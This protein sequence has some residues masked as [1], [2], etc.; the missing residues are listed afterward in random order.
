VIIR[1]VSERKRA[2]EALRAI[3]AGTAASKGGKL[4]RTL[5][6]HL[7][8]ALCVRYAFIAQC[9][10]DSREYVCTLAFWK[11]D[12]F[13]ENFSYQLTGTPCENVVAGEI[14]HYPDGVQALFPTDKVL[15]SLKAR[16][17]LGIPLC[18]GDGREIGYLAV[19]DDKRIDVTPGDM[20]ILRVFAVRASAELER[21]RAEEELRASEE[22]FRALFESA[23]IGISINDGHG[24]YLHANQAMLEM[25]GYSEEDLLGLS[26]FDVT[27]ADD[28]VVSHELFPQLIDGRLGGFQIEKRYVRKRGDAFWVN[29]KCAAV[30]D[31]T[32]KFLYAFAMAEDVTEQKAAQQALQRAHDEL[33]TRVEQRTTELRDM[34]VLLNEAKESAEAASRAK[35]EFLARMSHELRTPLNSILGYLQIFSRDLN[36]TPGQQQG[37]DVVRR[38]GEHLLAMITE[39]L[40]L[41]KIE[42]G[43]MELRPCDFNLRKLVEELSDAT[44]VRAGEKDLEF[45]AQIDA[46]LPFSVHGDEQ[47]L[48]QL[49]LNLLVNAAKFTDSGRVTFRALNQSAP[50]KIRFEVEDTGVGIAT[51]QLE[52]IFMPFHQVGNSSRLSEGT[53]LGLTI[54]RELA[55]MIGGELTVR[56]TPGSGSLFSVDISLPV[57]SSASETRETLNEQR[58]VGYQGARRRILVVDDIA[59][60]RQVIIDMLAPLGFALAEAETGAVA[61]ELAAIF[62]PDLVL[63]DLRMPDMD[64]YEAARRIRGLPELEKIIIIALS[65]SV[66][67]QTRAESMDAGCDD[68]LAKPVWLDDL[69]EMLRA[70][71]GF[72]WVY[73]NAER[74]ASMIPESSVDSEPLPRDQVRALLHLSRCGD[75][76]GVLARLDHIA[77]L[78]DHYASL[79]NELRHLAM[80]FRMRDIISRVQSLTF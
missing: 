36:L 17:Y 20:A 67:D 4:F 64:G 32:G 29:R 74:K 61:L 62:R 15:G 13:G 50:G 43:Q 28:L 51:E 40:D 14:R 39:I 71:L 25:L 79:V 49:L 80:D 23:P 53:G 6:Q 47:R 2:D 19:L 27:F 44:R 34:N 66:F 16:G 21:K 30:R 68:F 10:D 12:S 55:H 60:N 56:S 69:L 8:S 3:S 73:R 35:N 65:A 38:S 24:R 77:T 72:D 78:G 1:D 46:E 5:V 75:V 42:A 57:V 48:R 54:S 70:H 22:R 33:E 45:S 11:G 31:E 37:L 41:A 9:V 26:C 18:E 58:I 59:E 63:L 7:A 52:E 76:N